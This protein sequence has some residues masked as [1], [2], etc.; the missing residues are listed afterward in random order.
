MKKSTM[1]NHTKIANAIMY[2]IYKYVDTD[3]NLDE[4]SHDLGISKFHMHRIFK[5]E[6]EKNIY[7]SIKS[8]RLQ[9]ASSLLLTNPHATISEIANSC[10]YSSHTSF[11]KAFKA[12]FFVTPSAWRNQEYKK[13][14]SF[15]NKCFTDL[16]MQIVKMPKIDAYYIRH[17]GY[18]EKI[19]KAWQKLQ[20]WIYSNEIQEYQ[21]IALYH[22]NPTITPLTQCHYVACISTEQTLPNTSL[23]KLTIPK[24]IYAKFDFSGSYGD[25]LAFMHWVYFVWLPENAY[26][27]TTNPAYSIYHKNHFLE[28]DALFELS[29]YLPIKI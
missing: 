6:F 28:D 15:H 24:G 1:Q 23:P 11:I 25:V 10:G 8:I 26:E 16:E 2:Y 14:D 7:E 18:N 13:Y 22:D 5:K 3:I 12:R 21:Q 19:K 27:T 20:T 4:L 29:Y 9:K 17:K